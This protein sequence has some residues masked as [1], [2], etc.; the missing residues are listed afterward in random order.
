MRTDEFQP[1]IHALATAGWCVLP[2]FLTG[3]ATA[4]LRAE[5]LSLQSTP[6]FRAARTGAART[7]SVLRTDRTHWFDPAAL[8]AP[9]QVFVRRVDALRVALNRGL[10]LGLVDCEAHY[11][12]FPPGG[13]YARHRDGLRDSDARVVSTVFYLNPA[14]ADS[15]GG[16]LRLY[17]PEGGHHD[18]APRAGTLAVFLSARFDH[19]VLPATR[20]RLSIACW[21]RQQ[22]APEAATC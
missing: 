2:D 11:A 5:C 15:D 19:E 9:Q 6:G 4:T 3:A 20:P 12:A 17:L 21:L 8:T 10:L 7:A 18:I 16:A 13:G 22:P 1:A 14:W